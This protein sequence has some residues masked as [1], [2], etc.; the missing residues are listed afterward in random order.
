MPA[1]GDRRS[2][3][4]FSVVVKLLMRFESERLCRRTPSQSSPVKPL[5]SA[6]ASDGSTATN[7]KTACRFC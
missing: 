4:A 6:V 1:D 7:T 5:W 3:V 2:R